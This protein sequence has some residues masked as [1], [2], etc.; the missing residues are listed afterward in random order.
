MMVC[1]RTTPWRHGEGLATHPA[2]LLADVPPSS[3]TRAVRWCPHCGLRFEVPRDASVRCFEC[4]E[5]GADVAT[6]VE[7]EGSDPGMDVEVHMS[8]LIPEGPVRG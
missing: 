8:C 7:P 2:A 5:T 6:Y 3:V 1:T 4:G